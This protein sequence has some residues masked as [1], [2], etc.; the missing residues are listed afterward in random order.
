MDKLASNDDRR[1]NCI[2]SKTYN[3]KI[4]K[5][6][7]CR[8][9]GGFVYRWERCIF[10]LLYIAAILKQTVAQNSLELHGYKERTQWLKNEIIKVRRHNGKG[11]KGRT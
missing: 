4:N 2:W 10:V 6:S 9:L 3:F 1:T 5:Y 7:M 11:Y 8:P